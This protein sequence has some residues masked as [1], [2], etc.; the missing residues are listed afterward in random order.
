MQARVNFNGT[1]SE[2]IAVDN[3]V[4]QVDIPAPTLLS[5]YF[6]AALAF[7]FQDCNVGVYLRFRCTGKVFDLRRFNA[8]SKT[9]E[10]LICEIL[11]ADDADKGRH[12]ENYGSVF[13]DI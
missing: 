1:L 9:F 8:K 13:Y 3:G 12:T 4:E 7:A 6:A 11:H 2:A 10:T 5:I